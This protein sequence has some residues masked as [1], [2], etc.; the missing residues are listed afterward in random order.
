MSPQTIFSRYCL[1][2]SMSLDGSLYSLRV[3]TILPQLPQTTNSTTT[4][5]LFSGVSGNYLPLF[6]PICPP[7]SPFV[8]LSTPSSTALRSSLSVD[9]NDEV[10]SM[11][12]NRTSSFLLFSSLVNELQHR[13]LQFIYQYLN[14]M[15]DPKLISQYAV[16]LSLP[17]HSSGTTKPSASPSKARAALIRAFAAP[18]DRRWSL[19]S[20]RSTSP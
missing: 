1:Q 2:R 13:I 11:N 14:S 17:L 3:V 18:S 7:C 19:F 6:V 16:P 9:T 4:I 20:P 12:D 15:N 8:S 10:N 5:L